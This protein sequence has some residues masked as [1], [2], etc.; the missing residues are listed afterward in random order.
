MITLKLYGGKRP[1]GYLY[2]G[3][4]GG[5]RTLGSM[6]DTNCV[7]DGA[8]PF[9]LGSPMAAPNVFAVRM[10]AMRLLDGH[11]P[12]IVDAMEPGGSGDPAAGLNAEQCE[13]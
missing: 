6:E 2:G 13:A 10:H 5:Y 7:W 8:V 3:S 1:Y 11:F 4:G 12:A 9:V